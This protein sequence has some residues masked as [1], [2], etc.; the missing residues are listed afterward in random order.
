[1]HLAVFTLLI[2][3]GVSAPAVTDKPCWE[4]FQLNFK[5]HGTS[6]VYE[7]GTEVAGPIFRITEG[8]VRD[9]D[10][11]YEAYKYEAL[12]QNHMKMIVGSEA[13]PLHFIFG[14]SGFAASRADIAEGVAGHNWRLPTLEEATI[15]LQGLSE[16][17]IKMQTRKL[18]RELSKR[19]AARYG[20][21]LRENLVAIDL[22]CKL[23]T[24]K[25]GKD[26]GLVTFIRSDWPNTDGVFETSVP[27]V[28]TSFEDVNMK[29]VVTEHPNS[30]AIP[31]IRI[32]DPLY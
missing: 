18:E 28:N 8:L 25:Y 31:V 13:P 20:V 23:P 16:Y 11:P 32:Y 5:S 19:V 24:E 7:Y 1:M 12:Q 30:L 10:A 2:Y 27:F 3:L 29:E 4:E 26:S 15:I 17:K 6:Y 22:W 21:F 9:E 14:D